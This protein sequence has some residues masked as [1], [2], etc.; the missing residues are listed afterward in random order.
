M[1][2]NGSFQFPEL[3][4]PLFG[5]GRFHLP[6]MSLLEREHPLDLCKWAL[7][8]L[9]GR[10]GHGISSIQYDDSVGHLLEQFH[11]WPA[12]PRVSHNST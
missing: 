12:S 6:L 3:F 4:F 1:S 8:C 10:S 2:F 9:P 11:A 5:S 7:G